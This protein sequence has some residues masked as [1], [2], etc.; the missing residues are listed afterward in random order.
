MLSQGL[1]FLS[2]TPFRA[3]SDR[4]RAS[5]GARSDLGDSHQFV[6]IPVAARRATLV[7]PG[8]AKDVF[9]TT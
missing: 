3:K 8:L 2:R 1:R 5:E 7:G 4:T 6:G 9:E